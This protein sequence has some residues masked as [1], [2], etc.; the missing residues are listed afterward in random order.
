MELAATIKIE[1]IEYR[2]QFQCHHNRRTV[3]QN[4][5]YDVNLIPGKRINR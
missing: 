1:A 3:V 4:V 5:G 2:E